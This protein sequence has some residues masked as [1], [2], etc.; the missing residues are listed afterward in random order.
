MT[1]SD[2]TMH[3]TSAEYLPQGFPLAVQVVDTQPDYPSHTH[4]FTEIVVVTHG[5]GL[6][7]LPQQSYAIAAGDV[8]VIPRGQAH[9]FRETDQLAIVNVIYD[10]TVLAPASHAL[11]MLP[12][13]HALFVIEPHLRARGHGRGHLMVSTE[14]LTLL[15]AGIDELAREL[16]LQMPG[17]ALV[18]QAALTRLIVMLARWYNSTPE[19]PVQSVLALGQLHQY[20]LSH[21][22]EPVTVPEIADHLHC[23]PRT[24]QRTCRAMLGQSPLQYLTTVRLHEAARLLR[25]TDQPVTEIAGQVGYADSA[26]FSRQFH[27]F[28]DRSPRAYRR[29]C[30]GHRDPLT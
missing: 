3:L 18:A 1:N 6:H 28:H 22:A 4:N 29:V 8:F 30:R 2:I 14:Q 24:L 11:A 21:L 27:G 5:R 25:D 15:R 17:Y 13:Y 9:R 19:R 7:D 20:I 10:A 12:G 23:S 26:Y 16:T